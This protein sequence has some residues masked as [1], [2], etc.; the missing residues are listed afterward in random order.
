MHTSAKVHGGSGSRFAG[1]GVAGEEDG[2]K[3]ALP[4]L[5]PQAILARAQLQVSNVLLAVRIAG[6]AAQ[7]IVGAV[8]WVAAAG[9]GAVDVSGLEYQQ[10]SCYR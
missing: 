6:G 1:G 9:G 7:R 4:Q 2:G 5:P 10:E 3:G 8:S